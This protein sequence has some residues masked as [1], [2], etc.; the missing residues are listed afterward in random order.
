MAQAVPP[1]G[2]LLTGA[3]RSEG[4]PENGVWNSLLAIDAGGRIVAH[5]DKVHLVPLG[6]Y[7][8][9]H[10]QLAPLSGVIGRGSFEAGEEHVTLSLP[11]LPGFSPIICYEAIFPGAVTGEGERP[12]WLL[13]VTND[14]W[15]GVSSGPWQHLVSA[16]LRAV[17][18]GLPMMRAANTGVSAVIDS[19]GQV[20]AA[21]GMERQGIID[22]ALPPARPATPYSRWGDWTLV[23]LLVSLTVSMIAKKPPSSAS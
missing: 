14:A 9:F 7:I 8:P 13:N 18:E 6:E 3:A 23:L 17:E 11:G 22:H 15:F 10:H 12:R 2:Y 4:A 1:G 16:R 21:L 5:Y 19:Y 20:L